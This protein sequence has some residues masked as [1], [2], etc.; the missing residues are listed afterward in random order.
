VVKRRGEATSSRFSPAVL[1]LASGD[2]GGNDATAFIKAHPDWRPENE[3]DDEEKEE[4]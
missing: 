4:G 2:G 3:K 1:S